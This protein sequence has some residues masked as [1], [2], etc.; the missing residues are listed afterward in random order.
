LPFL[1]AIIVVERGVPATIVVIPEISSLLLKSDINPH[2]CEMGYLTPFLWNSSADS[3]N[4][5]VESIGISKKL[6]LALVS[7]VILGSGSRGHHDHIFLSHE[8][9][10]RQLL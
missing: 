1:T 7:T 4:I 5:V 9:G 10:S 6:L 3:V 2:C 8:C